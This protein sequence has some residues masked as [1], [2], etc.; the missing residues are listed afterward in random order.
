MPF[1]AGKFA[2]EM[3]RGM[4][5]KGMKKREMELE[6]QLKFHYKYGSGG[7]WWECE[8]D[9]KKNCKS[10]DAWQGDTI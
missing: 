5:Q 7:R 8:I 4:L 2:S 3:M 10:F 6:L 9:D 1:D